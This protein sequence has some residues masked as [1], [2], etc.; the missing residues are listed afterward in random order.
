MTVTFGPNL[1][2]KPPTLDEIVPSLIDAWVPLDKLDGDA[3][4]AAEDK[5]SDLAWMVLFIISQRQLER[6]VV[7]FE[8][9]ERGQP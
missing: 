2:S 3:L 6:G 8:P 5:L 1:R 7:S 9:D 4:T